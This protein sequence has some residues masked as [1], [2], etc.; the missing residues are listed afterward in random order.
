[1]AQLHDLTA[2]E[3][4]A[5]V[6]AR[7]VSPLE[8]VEHALDRIDRLDDRL[9]AFVTVTE[10]TAREQAKQAE[11]DVLAAPDL[12][13]LPPLLG[14]PTAIKDL[15]LTKGVRTQLGCVLFRDF[16]PDTDDYV[17][18]LLRAAGTIS[19]GKTATPEFGLPCYTETDIGPP[20][21]TPWDLTRLAGGSSG[22]AA[23]AVAAGLIPIAQ[24][25]DGGGSI[26]IPASVCGLV[27][28]KT[29]RGRI[30]RGPLDVDSTRLGVYGPLART[31]RDAAAFLDA[32]AIP[33]PGD[34]D[35]L[36]P[37]PPGETF[38]G[39]CDRTPQRLRIGRYIVPPIET[40]VDARVRAA[41]EDTSELLASLGH[42]I[43]DVACPIPPEAIPCFETVWTVG[44]LSAPIDPSREP[45]LRPL[46]R[47][48][49]ARG[50]AVSAAQYAQ[51]IGML[52]LYSRRG[53]AATAHLDAVLT[54]TLAALPPPIGWF[55]ADGDPAADFE[56]QKQFTPFTAIYNTTGQPAVSL[57]LHHSAEGLPIGIMLVGRPAGDAALLALAAQLEAAAPWQA[58]RPPIWHE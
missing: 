18:A 52:N 48:L 28:F 47:H 53:I 20:A 12:A 5:A 58:R 25:S 46:T 1:V 54:P 31:V 42:D 36:P 38:R 17:V 33:Q 2:L 44:A 34:P 49:R 15:N 50:A 29:S 37:L 39:W 24:G 13:Q 51:A 11:H 6:R 45:E 21:R 30:S 7:Q 19:L 3:A 35:P 57:P 41:W 14:V 32:T 55:T 43:V 4:A 10:D 56:R 9:G 8:L 40:S 16:V 22:G 27:G 26:R 23:A